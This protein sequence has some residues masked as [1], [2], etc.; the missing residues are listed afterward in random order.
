MSK[1]FYPSIFAENVMI[2]SKKIAAVLLFFSVL[3][4]HASVV[5]AS[6]R[7]VVMSFQ[8][9]MAEQRK[10]EMLKKISQ[11]FSKQ[12]WQ[13]M[14]RG[15][16]ILAIC[17]YKHVTDKVS[18]KQMFA[19][20]PHLAKYEQEIY[21]LVTLDLPNQAMIDLLKK[22]KQEGVIVV[23]A[24]NKSEE[25]MGLLQKMYP[26]LFAL[27]DAYYYGSNEHGY[28]PSNEFFVGLRNVVNDLAQITIKQEYVYVD[29]NK[30]HCDAA[31]FADYN[32]RPI[33][34]LS[35][36]KLEKNLIALGYLPEH[37]A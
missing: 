33:W 16:Q 9:V 1:K 2:N 15:I 18:L 13:E 28:K 4:M 32:V 27:F 26:E 36:E 22:L 29:A 30:R 19:Q 3:T 5:Q 37:S 35:A 21:E 12:T 34:F 25:V 6:K 20:Y 10:A 8:H 14:P 17:L 11:L 31:Q 23:L 7:A 24:T